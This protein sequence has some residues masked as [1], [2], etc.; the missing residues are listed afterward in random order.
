MNKGEMAAK[1]A[2][3]TGLSKA[4]SLEVI[5]ALFDAEASASNSALMTSRDF[6]LD[7]PVFA[8][9]LAAISPLFMMTSVRMWGFVPRK[10]P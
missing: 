1:L 4:K 6:A 8:A 2:A 5:N 3:K 9:S 7:R 10:A